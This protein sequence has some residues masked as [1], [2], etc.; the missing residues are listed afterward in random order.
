MNATP[1][2]LLL[3]LMDLVTLA[4][5][6]PLRTAKVVFV[7]SDDGTRPALTD[8]SGVARAGS[9]KRPDLGHKDGEVL[10]FIN[11]LL[12]DL[13]TATDLAEG[14]KVL[15]GRIEIEGD[16]E[17]GEAWVYL[18][19]AGEAPKDD[20]VR[21]KRRFD[22]S[23]LGWLFFT[24]ALFS[25]LAA[26]EQD[27]ARQKRALDEEL[28]A[29]RRFAIDMGEG[30][31][32]FSGGDDADGQR[33]FRFELVG[34]WNETSRRFLWGWA[35]E[36]IP[37]KLREGAEKRR[38]ASTDLGLRA[39]TAPDLGCPEKMAERLARHAAVFMGARGLYRA[40]F[41]S[42]L[43]KGFMYLALKDG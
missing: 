36:S 2:E 14:L 15:K 23:E 21:M 5:P 16:G 34:S 42:E 32:T 18:V 13:A 24:P 40:P 26:T 20:R 25:A 35:N 31:I 39:F 28:R 43:A 41:S 1:D 27:E 38:R 4:F 29:F 3:E 30:T 7:P 19:E 22:R 17:D 11:A 6:E 9:V 12:G 10:D 37:P 33:V 8:L